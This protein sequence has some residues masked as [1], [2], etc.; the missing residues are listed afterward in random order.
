MARVGEAMG[1]LPSRGGDDFSDGI[2]YAHASERLITVG[3]RLCERNQIRGVVECFTAPQIASA[4]KPADHLIADEEHA[5]LFT[6]LRNQRPVVGR[7]DDHAA[8]TLNGLSDKR[9]DPI[10]A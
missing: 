8:C 4:T 2:A 7:G 6:N 3:D 9:C 1:E 5:A 10:S